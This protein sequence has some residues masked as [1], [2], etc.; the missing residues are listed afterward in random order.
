[1]VEASDE[2]YTES[3]TS[4]TMEE[5]AQRLIWLLLGSVRRRIV[6]SDGQGRISVD[7]FPTAFSLGGPWIGQWV[8][9]ME[10]DR[11]EF[12][13][14]FENGLDSAKVQEKENAVK[15][16]DEVLKKA[17]TYHDALDNEIA[18]GEACELRLDKA[19]T[20]KSGV[21]HYTNISIDAWVQKTFGISLFNLPQP[22]SDTEVNTSQDAPPKNTKLDDIEK[23]PRQRRFDALGVEINEILLRE[24][25]L[26][27]SQV[28]QKLR[29]QIGKPNT[30]VIGNVG[31]GIKWT[32]D[33]GTEK[34]L[35]IGSLAERI[36]VWKN[37]EKQG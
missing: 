17:M 25:K 31:N 28:M 23:K 24:P 34:E 19:T 20:D 1:M 4:C 32:N 9:L 26:T 13:D 5:V 18:M 11:L 7:Q 16:W 22:H 33:E 10:T 15:R 37:R 35:T 8:A 27:A 21:N 29:S 30:C 36:R 6:H 3:R 14:A 12:S 2:I